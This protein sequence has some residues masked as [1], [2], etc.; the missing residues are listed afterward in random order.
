LGF[1]EWA[2]ERKKH[3]ERAMAKV[4]FPAIEAKVKPVHFGLRHT[5]LRLVAPHAAGPHVE[6]STLTIP[7]SI[8]KID[9]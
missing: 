5:A 6:A 1:T 4:N 3:F 7:S 9:W 2:N 8:I